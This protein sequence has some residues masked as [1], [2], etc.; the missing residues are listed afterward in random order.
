MSM[1]IHHL[2]GVSLAPGLLMECG[3]DAT[4]GDVA[5]SYKRL[6]EKINQ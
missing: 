3:D 2:D 5:Y 4:V 6:P 1:I